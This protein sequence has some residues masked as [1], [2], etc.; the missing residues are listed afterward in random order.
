MCRIQCTVVPLSVESHTNFNLSRKEEG[1]IEEATTYK[2]NMFIFGSI[3]RLEEHK[4]R[5]VRYTKELTH[6]R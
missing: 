4:E 1:F 5:M 2:I 6:I 3:R